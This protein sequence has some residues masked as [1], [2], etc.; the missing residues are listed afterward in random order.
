[1]AVPLAV[2]AEGR[3]FAIETKDLE[4]EFRTADGAS[5]RVIGGIS[6]R[7]AAGEIVAIVGPS[8]GGKTTLLR[9]LAGILTPSSGEVF[10]AGR[11]SEHRPGACGYVPQ[12]YS[13]FP[14]LTVR[15]NILY[16]LRLGTR[17]SKLK[18]ATE[19][20]AATGLSEFSDAYPNSLS[21][22]MK[23]RVAIARALA[24]EPDVLLLDEPFS[25]LDIRTRRDVRDYLL[26]VIEGTG[27]AAIIVTHD[28]QDAAYT[29]DRILFFSPRPSVIRAELKVPFSRPRSQGLWDTREFFDFCR[30]VV[31][32]ASSVE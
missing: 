12:G 2:N 16:S 28:L 31:R 15:E 17:V 20:L 8:G 19:L 32:A 3:P 6:F 7:L 23:Q 1:M 30:V 5:L 13:L 10:I 14:W 29:A 26:G 4:F 25:A 22:G 27:T 21:G 24:I 18:V 9:L 11:V